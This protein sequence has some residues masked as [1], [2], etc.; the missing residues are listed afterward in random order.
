MAMTSDELA[1]DIQDIDRLIAAL[2][3]PGSADLTD[4][5]DLIWLL[6]RLR[7]ISDLLA[8]RRAQKGKKIVSLALWRYGSTGPERMAGIG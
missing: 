1:Q 8:L 4:P 6:E 3:A 7:S 5:D 2:S